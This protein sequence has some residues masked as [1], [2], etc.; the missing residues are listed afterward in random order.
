MENMGDIS[1]NTGNTG[2]NDNN[3][4]YKENFKA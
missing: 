1:N 2:T 4:D 3:V